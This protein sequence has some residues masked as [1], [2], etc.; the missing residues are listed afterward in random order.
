MLVVDASVV[1][2]AS[3]AATGLQSLGDEELVAPTLMWSEA[4]SALHERSCRGQISVQDGRV[5]HT[6]LERCLV[7]PRDHDE[8]GAEAWRVADELGWAKTYDAEYVAL[9]RLLGCRLVT[10]D[11]RLRRGADRLG[12]VVGPLEL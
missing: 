5:A 3:F 12:F 11:G 9:A 1:V 7:E 8:L 2:A 6:E 4:R 10:L